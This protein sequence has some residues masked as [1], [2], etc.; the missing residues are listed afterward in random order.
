MPD[1]REQLVKYLTDAHSI[2][3]QALQ[4]LRLAPRIAGEPGL[5]SALAAHAGETERHERLVRARLAAHGAAP[6]RGKDVVMRVGGV[7]FVVFAAVQPD[8]PGKL[9]AH[10]YSYE[11]LEAASYELLAR[12]AA[13]AGDDETERTA[14]EILAEEQA[15]GARIEELFDATADASLRSG[16]DGDLRNRLRK[17]LADAHALEAQAETL[18]ARAPKIAGDDE[19]ARVYEKH[20]DETRTHMQIV[21][22]RLA[23]LGGDN[24]TPKDAALRA[25]ALHWGAFF[26]A[27][28]DTPGKL[29]A[30]TY[31]FEHLE[32][33]GYLQLRRVAGRA[34]ETA[35][36]ADA[37]R[38]LGEE[39]NAADAIAA[40]FDRAAQASFDA[41]G[42]A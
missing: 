3:V 14:R 35:A 15:M 40:L 10:A 1:L 27:H 38:I 32:I 8:T 30:F 31:A 24:S 23:A 13:Q 29:A 7:G 2:E 33:G 20:L 21:D 11:H 17:Y 16:G 9:A 36:V 5:R 42:A 39:R 18:L 37:E 26:R 12:V 25:G 6:S 22:A 41:V 19:L 34:G 4:Q 28:P